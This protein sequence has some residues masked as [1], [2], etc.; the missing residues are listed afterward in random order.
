MAD[1]VSANS[2]ATPVRIWSREDLDVR[3]ENLNFDPVRALELGSAVVSAT[4]KLSALPDHSCLPHPD[5]FMTRSLIYSSNSSS[6]P[7]RNVRILSATCFSGGIS[8]TCALSRRMFTTSCRRYP[9]D[10]VRRDGVGVGILEYGVPVRR[11]CGC[12]TKLMAG[13]PPSWDFSLS[14]CLL[15]VDMF[16]SFFWDF[17]F[18]AM[19][20]LPRGCHFPRGTNSKPKHIITLDIFESHSL[21]NF[22][23]S[24]LSVM[25]P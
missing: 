8:T 17:G 1:V 19:L 24:F 20:G 2:L 3:S 10:P 15:G 12:R 14:F 9:S 4:G 21:I 18:P 11:L 7:R 6:G 25:R 5:S 23:K 13:I 22:P 16:T